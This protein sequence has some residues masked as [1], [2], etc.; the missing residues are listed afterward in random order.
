[1][2]IYRFFFSFT[3]CIITL[4][5]LRKL[6]QEAIILFSKKESGIYSNFQI[7]TF[8]T[9]LHFRPMWE[10]EANKKGGRWVITLNKNQRRTDLDNLWLDVV[11]RYNCFA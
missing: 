2:I 1:M 10:D 4:N 9:T 5:W 3:V 6:R 7:S 8:I 11:G